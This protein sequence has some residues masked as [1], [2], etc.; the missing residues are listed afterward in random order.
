MLREE[1]SNSLTNAFTDAFAIAFAIS[2]A[3]AHGHDCARYRGMWTSTSIPVQGAVATTS[4]PCLTTMP[5]SPA[6]CASF[7][8]PNSLVS[9]PM[10]DQIFCS[11]SSGCSS[12][13]VQAELKEI[14]SPAEIEKLQRALMQAAAKKYGVADFLLD[15]VLSIIDYISDNVNVMSH[16][17]DKHLGQPSL[18]TSRTT[19]DIHD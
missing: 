1:T 11:S 10:S 7:T 6:S 13:D 17:I 5:L 18:T 8:C 9:K 2:F 3:N 19:C 16:I 12:L 15:S 4:V 14:E